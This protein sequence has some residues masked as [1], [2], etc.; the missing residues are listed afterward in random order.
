MDTIEKLLLDADNILKV[1]EEFNLPDVKPRIFDQTD[2][3]PGVGV[4]NKQVQFRAA[5][6]ILIEGSDYYTAFI[7]QQVIAKIL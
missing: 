5:E 1:I 2:A 6:R 7:G 4:S 3:G